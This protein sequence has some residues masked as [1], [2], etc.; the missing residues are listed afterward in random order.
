LP[1]FG[2]P[3]AGRDRQAAER[4]LP[5]GMD[6]LRELLPKERHRALKGHSKRV[7][8]PYVRTGDKESAG[9]MHPRPRA[10]SKSNF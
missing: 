3:R 6:K 7:W 5:V 1:H 10:L 2:F 9:W 8:K 4:H